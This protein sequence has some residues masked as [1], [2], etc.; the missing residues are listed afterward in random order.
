MQRYDQDVPF[1]ANPDATH[2]YQAA[3]K[4]VLQRFRPA[5]DQSWTALDRI[6]GKVDGFGTWPFAGLTWLQ[7]QGLDLTS[8]ELMD[9]GRFAAEGRPYLAEFRG[10]EFAS[11]DAGLDLT[12][13][14]A[15][16]AI[17]VEKVRSEVR[18][19]TIDDIR[20]AVADGCLVMCHVNSKNLNGREGYTGHFVIVKG[21]DE[22]GLIL[23][24]PGP[25][26]EANRKV[27]L[28][29]FERAWGYPTAAVKWLVVIRDTAR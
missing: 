12:H 5:H 1:I 3:L 11:V 21:F 8:V 4:M 19:P 24:D 6:T 10:Q 28:D 2:C 23:H 18:V 20:R 16:A 25:P 22:H 13:V 9:N 26:S 17:F 29:A 14:Q 7:G 15:E 27:S